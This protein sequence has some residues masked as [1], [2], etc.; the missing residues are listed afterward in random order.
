[1]CRRP[2]CLTS[3]RTLLLRVYMADSDPSQVVAAA[4]SSPLLDAVPPPSMVIPPK[5]RSSPPSVA[6]SLDG[7]RASEHL[8]SADPCDGPTGTSTE[9]KAIAFGMDARKIAAILA[10]PS[11]VSPRVQ[12]GSSSEPISLMSSRWGRVKE[13]V[14]EAANENKMEQLL[15]SDVRAPHTFRASFGKAERRISSGLETEAPAIHSYIEPTSTLKTGCGTKWGEPHKPRER[16]LPTPRKPGVAEL[17]GHSALGKA[18]VVTAG[19]SSAPASLAGSPKLYQP[20]PILLP[21]IHPG[22]TRSAATSPAPTPARIRPLPSAAPAW[23]WGP[24]AT[25]G[26]GAAGSSLVDTQSAPANLLIATGD[27]SILPSGAANLL[28]ATGGSSIQPRGTFVP[29]SGTAP[30]NPKLRC[31]Q[32]AGA[33]FRQETSFISAIPGKLPDVPPASAERGGRVLSPVDAPK[34]QARARLIGKERTG[35]VPLEAEAPPADDLAPFSSRAQPTPRF[36]RRRPPVEERAVQHLKGSPY[37]LPLPQKDTAMRGRSRPTEA[38]TKS[39]PASAD[40]DQG[41]FNDRSATTSG[42][43]STSSSEADA[44]NAVRRPSVLEVS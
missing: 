31:R 3:G 42:G 37:A 35:F 7:Q 27:S 34:Q 36:V 4:T 25:A 29:D 8:D 16:P 12:P 5:A 38:P 14:K 13:A 17:L 20:R 9:K 22:G 1:V 15:S 18:T 26:P 40:Q 6:G 39:A 41:S 2:T 28:I 21:S 23:G 33:G 43:S 32:Q 10:A 44:D 30:P 19:T 24:R 11:C